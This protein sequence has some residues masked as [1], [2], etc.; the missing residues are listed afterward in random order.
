LVNRGFWKY[1]FDPRNCI[2]LTNSE[3]LFGWHGKDGQRYRTFLRENY[4]KIWDFYQKALID[5]QSTYNPKPDI[6]DMQKIIRN[7]KL[8]LAKLGELPKT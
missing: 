8:R 4:P 6:S 5:A 2:T 7:L 3:Q 1:R